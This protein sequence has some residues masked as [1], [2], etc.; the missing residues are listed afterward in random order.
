MLF[1]SQKFL[2]IEN[3]EDLL[4]L[5]RS[6]ANGVL[7]NQVHKS[8]LIR[9]LENAEK[10]MPFLSERDSD[11][12]SNKEKII[13]IF[14]F[15]IPYFVGPLS[16]RHKEQ[17]S[18]CWMVRKEGEN[19]RIYPWNIEDIVDYEKSNE[20]FIRRMTNKCTYLIGEDVL[21]KNSLLYSKYMVLNELNN[22]K[23]KGKIGRAHV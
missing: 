19:G 17:G 4:P 22:L 15:R 11:G 20:A 16:D 14:E 12:I 3:M 21:P 9:I 18:N 8:E 6:Q 10:Y 5:Q 2:G 13:S 1:R 7:P 23:V